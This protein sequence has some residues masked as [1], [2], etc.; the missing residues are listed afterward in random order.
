VWVC[1][2]LIV[3]LC[4]SLCFW[5]SVYVCVWVCVCLSLSVYVSLSVYLPLSV[6]V[7][8]IVFLCVSLCFWAPSIKCV[9]SALLELC[10][11]T[12][13]ITSTS[14]GWPLIFPLGSWIC[15]MWYS[16]WKDAL[17]NLGDEVIVATKY[18]ERLRCKGLSDGISYE[19]SLFHSGG[20]SKPV[21]NRKSSRHGRKVVRTE[22]LTETWRKFL[23]LGCPQKDFYLLSIAFNLNDWI[24]ARKIVQEN[25]LLHT[26]HQS[27]GPT[28]A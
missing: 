4:V 7:S 25:L 10:I 26:Q 24:G 18:C 28:R 20:T 8:L 13:S 9:D 12:H 23:D 19:V 15:A 14:S 16:S 1:V 21:H 22:G 3:F 11:G 6:C 2:S 5:V 17:G 27:W